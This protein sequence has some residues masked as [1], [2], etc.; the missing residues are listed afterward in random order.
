MSSSFPG[1][2]SW[3][4]NRLPLELADQFLDNT[5]QLTFEG[6]R[7]GEGYF[8]ADGSK[9]VFQSER[10]SGNPFYQI[11]LLD[12][13]TGDTER[14]SPG[15]G[16]TTCAWIHPVEDAVLFASTHDDAESKAKQVAELEERKSQRIRKYSWDYD[17]NFDIYRYD[18]GTKSYTNLTKTRGYDAEGAYS[19]D[20]ERIVF[21]SNRHA[22]SGH[23]DPEVRK[24]FE[25]KK[26]YLMDIY[27]MAA[28]G[29][30]VRRLTDVDGY[31]GGPFFNADGTRICWRR[32]NEK[33]DQAEIWTMAADG[34]DQRQ[35]T[36]LGAMSWAPFFHPSGEYLIFN[37]NLQ[38][39]AN[40]ELYI[41]DAAG[42]KDP[43]RVTHSDGFDG[44]ACFHPNGRQLS[45]TSNRSPAKQSQIY[46]AD[47][48]HEAARGALG[49]GDSSP[50]APDP[51]PFPSPDLAAALDRSSPEISAADLMAHIEN[52]ASDA[53]QGR[54]TGTEGER[55]ATRY[56]ADAFQAFG[57]KPAG[58][59]GKFFHEFEFTAG[60]DLG[61]NNR[62]DA[63]GIEFETGGHWRPLSFSETGKIDPAGVV[64]AG[65]GMEIPE[66]DDGE[67]AYSSYFHLNV[68]DKWVLVFR[69]APED[70]DKESRRRYSRYSS[71][72]HK[73]L[74]A[75]KKGAR[76]MIVVSGPRSKVLE[77]L[78]PLAYDASMASSG[79]SAISISDA[80]AAKLL[81][82]SGKDLGELQDALNQ[83]SMVPGFTLDGVEIGAEID[84]VQERKSGRNVL[85]RLS[86]GN[87]DEPALV[88]GAHVDHLGTKAGSNSRAT[89][90]ERDRIHHGA[91]DNASGIAAM[92]EIAQKFSA[93]Q[94]EGK[95]TPARDII[96]AAWSG[97]ELGLLGVNRWLSDEAESRTGSAD[98]KLGD[99]FAAN[100]NMDMVG[101]LEKK[102]VLQGVGSSPVWK[103]E[104]ER[105][106][107]PVGL[108]ITIQNDSYLP[109]D[110]TA[111]YLRGV[112]VLNAFTGAHEDYHRPTDTADKI[113]S[114][115]CEKIT[116]LMGLIARALALDP[117]E[118]E[119]L[120][121]T[122]P[123]NQ[124]GRGFRVYLGT[125][126]DYAQGDVVG[127][128]L[129]GVGKLGPAQK[130]G[131]QAG[132]VIVSLA[133]QEIKNIYDYTYVMGDLKPG[134]ETTITVLRG[135][136]K[137]KMR[138]TPGSRD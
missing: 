122:K 110:A 72:R 108:P 4:R 29:S 79:V 39:F 67:E 5:R 34:S 62:I 17:E 36:G 130:A 51:D 56:V 86:S 88:I 23:L 137:V 31:D 116:R 16:K 30:D 44:L 47:W 132:D 136:K 98:G 57:L 81:E 12:L 2:G 109:T 121:T 106:N 8:S 77:Q 52:L 49:L 27:T 7:S 41:V 127:V 10:Q 24:R 59:E 26:S 13:E 80:L 94:A 114:G 37:T 120:E 95:F 138:I 118:P 53:M 61:E 28:D 65:Y 82:G 54:L 35:L 104:I 78:V 68:K 14:V 66:G 93:A 125:I 40:F 3:A 119:Y 46:L 43:V 107:A 133:G 111:F 18:R 75:R 134:E 60:V 113:N 112:P 100:L 55:L 83:G 6:R 1:T 64:F 71:L 99:Y 92:L 32:F 50:D 15:H 74:T 85:A 42:K 22:Y 129:S 76:G 90:E 19:P 126:P 33:G 135:E 128:K 97:E 103:P 38:G 115:G 117:N 124:G 105:R 9:M 91:D 123:E 87:P 20:G 69:Y 84:I 102:L 131:V 45:W 58:A 101:R 25:M 63:R 21:A 11:Y 48:D 73:A 89:D 70:V 96:F